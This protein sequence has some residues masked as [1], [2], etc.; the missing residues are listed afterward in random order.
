M[1]I[2]KKMV[3][4]GSSQE[5]DAQVGNTSVK[6]KTST[7]GGGE[8]KIECFNNT[9]KDSSVDVLTGAAKKKQTGR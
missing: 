3:G 7:R 5:E 6:Q 4:G 9:I 1:H 8:E 2:L